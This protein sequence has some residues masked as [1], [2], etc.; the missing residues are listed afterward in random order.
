MGR[1]ESIEGEHSV[2]VC[3]AQF[4]DMHTTALALDGRTR[5]P[6]AA[7]LLV[8]GKSVFYAEGA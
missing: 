3:V 2:S 4:I 5:D 1:F 6:T 8:K 7:F